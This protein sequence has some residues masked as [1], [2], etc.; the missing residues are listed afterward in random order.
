MTTL[1]N[2]DEI[3]G[4]LSRHLSEIMDKETKSLSHNNMSEFHLIRR[5]R[6]TLEE[7]QDV[8]EDD[9]KRYSYI[10]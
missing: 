1:R 9:L 7:I 5:F 4:L 6:Y 8:I 3:I 10:N 2:G